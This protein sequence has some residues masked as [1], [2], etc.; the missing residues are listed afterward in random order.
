MRSTALQNRYSALTLTASLAVSILMP[1]AAHAVG[2]ATMEFRP[3]CDGDEDL[4]NVF[5]GP[6]P[7]VEG[8]TKLTEGTCYTFDVRDPTSLQTDRLKAGD[9]LDIDIMVN[10]PD[11]SNITR[12]R[13]WVAYDQTVL[14]GIDATVSPLF[15]V[16]TPGESGFTPAE[17]TLKLSGTA[18]QP[19][20]KQRFAVARV[21]FRVLKDTLDGTPLVFVEATGDTNAKTG[22][23]TG[24]VPDEQN[25]LSTVNGSLY[26]QLINSAA[27][28]AS[29]SS[30]SS[31]TGGTG[32]HD[33]AASSTGITSAASSVTQT[34]VA[35]SAGTTGT[36]KA[37]TMLQVQGVR[38][39]TDGSS[40]FLA[41]DALPSSELAGYNIYYGTVSG[42]YIQRRTVDKA[43]TSLTIRALPVGTTYYFAV[44]AY[45]A[46]GDE[47]MFSQEVGVS[48]GNPR[49][50]TSPLNANSLPT[51]TPPTGGQVSGETGVTSTL[52]F[53]ILG[54]AA[55]G[56]L[57][58]ARRQL[59]ISSAS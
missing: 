23:F 20:S 24:Q 47:T 34:S 16:P 12:F 37:F 36:Q 7:D 11:R 55:V 35:S 59:Q 18:T 31:A 14:E 6:S 30:L 41:W 43:A 52:F 27:S 40:V 58:A 22:A 48:V 3:H 46:A 26:V 29:N 57:I 28:A 2:N 50:S 33:A 8:L 39:T 15:P 49:T 56:T 10:N 4:E 21:R 17:G 45:N 38:I 51:K 19:V 5:G 13:A 42:R 44:R 53:L 1:F 25:A 9:T 54:C 32:S